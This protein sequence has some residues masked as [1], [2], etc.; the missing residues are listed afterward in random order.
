MSIYLLPTGS[1][2]KDWSWV[3]KLEKII[4]KK[5]HLRQSI[6]LAFVA[7][8]E[9][10]KLNSR[11]R[12]KNKI[13]DVLSFNLDD[14]LNKTGA[15][16]DQILGEV[17]ICWPVLKKQAKQKGQSL[18]KELQLLLVHGTLH[19]LGYDHELATEAKVMESL[20]ERIL[21]KL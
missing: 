3:K 16:S 21:A 11:Y 18:T 14:E 2:V 1:E 7:T 15:G 20:E 8:K 17:I 19:L 9:I 13:T 6:S 5:F 10:K 4:S 12:H